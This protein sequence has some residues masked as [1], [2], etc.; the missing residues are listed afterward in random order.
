MEG[1][2]CWEEHSLQWQPSHLTGCVTLS[3]LLELSEPLS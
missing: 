1:A 2:R 3:Q